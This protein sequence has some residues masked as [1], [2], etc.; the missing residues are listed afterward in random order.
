M[1]AVSKALAD[2]LARTVVRRPDRIRVVV[3]GID[4]EVYHPQADD[5][6]IRRE[7]GIPSAVPIIGSI[8]RLESVKGYDVMVE[9]FARL[10]AQ[11]ESQPAPVLVV[12]GDG[13]ERGRLAS[14]V[15]RRG[16][17]GVA[18]LVGWRDDVH[19]LHASFS[20]FTMSSRSEGTSVSLLEAMGAAIC[21]VVTD[22]GGNSFVLGERLRHRLVPP[23][24]PRA[25]ASAWQQ[26]LSN[27]TQR[28]AD[29]QEA[30]SRV[31]ERFALRT[32]VEEYER[33]YLEGG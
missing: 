9:A 31:G 19:A 22:V 7:L 11:W 8:G 30:R 28:L 6:A 27:P 26:A 12:A 20:V 5:G 13:L 17:E 33:L 1:V 24:D 32:M 10:R 3:N 2:Q 4:P 25:L 18:H 14:L 29:G 21:P 15:Q 23:E 16:L